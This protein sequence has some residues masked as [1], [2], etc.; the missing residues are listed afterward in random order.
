[1]VLREQSLG[2][3]ARGPGAGPQLPL[4]LPAARLKP[5]A[6]QPVTKLSPAGS[7]GARLRAYS[8]L[9]QYLK[10]A[11]LLRKKGQTVKGISSEDKQQGF[12]EQ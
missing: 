3:T 11:D 10:A 1:M 9:C 4:S 2:G 12:I 5:Q 8:F 6:G 7:W